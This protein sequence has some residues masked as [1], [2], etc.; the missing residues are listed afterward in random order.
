MHQTKEKHNLP[1]YKILIGKHFKKLKTT[2]QG[3]LREKIKPKVPNA[4]FTETVL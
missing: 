4:T 1:N 3:R 2:L